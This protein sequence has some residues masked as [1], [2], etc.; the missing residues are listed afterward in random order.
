MISPKTLQRIAEAAKR[1]LM[2]NLDPAN[3]VDW[4]HLVVYGGS[5]RAARNWHE[6]HKLVRALD[7]LAADETLCVQSGRAVYVAKTHPGAPRLEGSG[8]VPIGLRVERGCHVGRPGR[9]GK[10]LLRP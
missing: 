5:G 8:G 9:V 3:A 1:M 2:N 7:Q 10:V 4:E 6:Y